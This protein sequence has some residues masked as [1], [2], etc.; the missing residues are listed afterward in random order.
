MIW[1]GADLTWGRFCLG[2]QD[3]QKEL[4]YKN[5]GA[6]IYK[7]GGELSTGGMNRAPQA[8]VGESTRGEFPPFW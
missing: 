4:K 3:S 2:P 1:S 8:Q 5:V 7:V 6:S